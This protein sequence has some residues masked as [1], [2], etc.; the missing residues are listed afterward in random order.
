MSS[1]PSTWYAS[2][3]GQQIGPL[4]SADIRSMAASGQLRPD[5]Y[6]CRDGSDWVPASRVKGLAFAVPQPVVPAVVADPPVA[7][8]RIPCQFCG[9]MVPPAAIKCRFCNEYLDGR[10]T[11]SAYAPQVLAPAPNVTHVH[12]APVARWSPGVAAV[13]SF[14]IPG[15]GQIYKG[16]V[17]RGFFY[18][19]LVAAGY[20]ALIVPGLILHL[21]IVIG[22]AT[23]NP[24][25]RT[26]RR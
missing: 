8:D 19:I 6:V 4:T 5:S 10:E 24:Y 3:D 12:A 14:L 13:L 1:T 11:P 2:I 9:E 15:L 22:A 20:F 7:D 25:P 26:R 23:G 17:L 18:M 16:Q 21:L